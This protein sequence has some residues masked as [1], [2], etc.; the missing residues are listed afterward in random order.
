V[1]LA[2]VF[3]ALGPHRQSANDNQWNRYVLAFSGMFFIWLALLVG[4]VFALSTNRDPKTI[5][6]PIE[7]LAQNITLLLIISAFLSSS[8]LAAKRA[9]PI[10]ILL[11]VLNLAGYVLTAINWIDLAGTE[12]FNLSVYGISWTGISLVIS[13]I[14]LLWIAMNLQSIR[15]VPLKLVMLSVLVAGSGWTLW[16]STHATP[17]EEEEG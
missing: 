9:K 2:G 3:M 17:S 1:E 12:D 5:L 15:D 4:M 14:A 8:P 10:I 13:G 16:Q 7:R 6:P 11:I